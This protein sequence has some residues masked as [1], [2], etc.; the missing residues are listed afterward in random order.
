MLPSSIATRGAR[1]APQRDR[2]LQF[3]AVVVTRHVS[4][5]GLWKLS[6]LPVTRHSDQMSRPST[7]LLRST[8]ATP[9]EQTLVIPKRSFHCKES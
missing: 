9:Y 5:L 8:S 7:Q 6:T 4:D 2:R 3:Q 1:A